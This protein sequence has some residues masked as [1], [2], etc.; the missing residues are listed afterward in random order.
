MNTKLIMRGL[1][2]MESVLWR[3][4]SMPDILRRVMRGVRALLELRILFER[5]ILMGGFGPW[6]L[7]MNFYLGY[8]DRW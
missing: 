5:I 1:V 7:E 2:V 6:L 8:W 4:I 3:R